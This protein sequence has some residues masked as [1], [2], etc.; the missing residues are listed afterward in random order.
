MLP[1]ALQTLIAKFQDNIEDYK[2]SSY[3][4][5]QL[6][7]E[8]LDKFIKI[9]GWDADN[10]AGLHESFKEVIHEDKIRIGATTKAPDYCVQIGGRKLFYIEAK[11]PS[12]K[13]IDDADAAFQVRR[14]GWTAQMPACLLTDF[15]E[16]SVYN[17]GIKPKNT[18]KS[19]TARFFYCRYDE[20]DKKNPQYPECENNWS[21]LESLFSKNAVIRGSLEK[22]KSRDKKGTQEVDKEFL[23]EIEDW[24]EQL[25]N[26]LV[27]RNKLTERELNF[28]VQKISEEEQFKINC[29]D[30]EKE[31]ADVFKDGGFDIVIGNPPYV[32]SEE[33]V[34]TNKELRNYASSR[35]ETAKGNWDMYCI[36]TEKAISF[37]R[38][39]GNF[40]FII[41]SKFL[42]APYGKYLKEYVSNFYIY[43]IE[44]YTNVSV[45]VSDRKI[46]VYPII[47][48]VS[49]TNEINNGIYNKYLQT[50]DGIIK[51]LST[52]FQINKQESEWNSKFSKNV[53]LIEKIKE[54]SSLLKDSFIIENSATVNEAYIIKDIIMESE[55]K[56]TELKLINTGTIDRYCLLWGIEHTQ[57]LNGKYYKPVV[58]LNKLKEKLP[59]RTATI[60]KNRIVFAGMVKNIEA[61]LIDENYYSAKSTTVIYPKDEQTSLYYALGLLNS[62]LVNFYFKEINKHNAM[63][64]GFITVSKKI[65]DELIYYKVDLSNKSEREQH[66]KI[67]K[68]VTQMLE[69]KKKEQDTKDP[70]SKTILQRRIEGIDKDIDKAV[71]E[72]YG[73]VEDI[74]VIEGQ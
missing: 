38:N 39:D 18:D 44:D 10:E 55:N 3:N 59:N 61:T 4:E 73:V 57:Y 53:S 28:A 48:L 36:Y 74:E 72:L 7:R 40:G 56:K 63:S 8:F 58:S 50:K 42:S 26:N 45:F 6:R 34:K 19:G 22:S 71:Y 14:Y 20:L 16:F 62:K 41:P 21:F 30:W 25:T 64:G 43:N 67:I 51:T 5:T 15:E 65:I 69:L 46:N 68:Y 27:L 31:F 24:R 9:L 32:D 35:Y 2:H 11:K 1:S 66:D 37:L 52:T 13:I 47:L 49:K 17:T 60:Q 70:Q 54:K 29:F 33:M 23:K 12:V